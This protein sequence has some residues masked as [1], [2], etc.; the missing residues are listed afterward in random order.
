ME[1]TSTFM[2]SCRL[3]V[4]RSA[5]WAKA[6]PFA[7]PMAINT[8]STATA[9]RRRTTVR[10]PVTRRAR[11]G[12]WSRE[13]VVSRPANAVSALPGAGSRTTAHAQVR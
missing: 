4:V 10:P 12:G 1:M 11:E 13:V 9:Q 6:G 7:Q 8:A 2:S 5:S 3:S